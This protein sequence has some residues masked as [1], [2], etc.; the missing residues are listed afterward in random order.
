MAST[1]RL[2][3]RP[4]DGSVLSLVSCA[5]AA[6]S[7][8]GGCSTTP[9]IIGVTY[10]PVAG[11][12]LLDSCFLTG[13]VDLVNFLVV[14]GASAKLCICSPITHP[15]RCWLGRAAK[16]V[17]QQ[18][19]KQVGVTARSQPTVIRPTIP[20]PVAAGDAHIDRPPP[21]VSSTK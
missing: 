17:A 3:E 21:G 11:N 15:L 12:V 8:P 7:S 18:A 5:I 16:C 19:D 6:M 13:T 1:S 9:P 14:N 20:P 2:G 10:R 4:A